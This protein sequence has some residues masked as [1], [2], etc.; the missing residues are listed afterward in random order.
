[1]RKAGFYR[2]LLLNVV[3]WAAIAI[4]LLA[5]PDERA[6]LGGAVWVR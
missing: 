4:Y 1:M 6:M 2:L 3:F 5:M